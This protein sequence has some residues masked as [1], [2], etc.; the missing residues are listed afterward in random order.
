MRAGRAGASL[1]HWLLLSAALVAIAPAARAQ[2]FNWTGANSTDWAGLGNWT[3]LGIPVSA[4]PEGAAVIVNTIA[5]NATITDLSAFNGGASFSIGSLAIGSAGNTTGDVTFRF[6]TPGSI[7]DHSFDAGSNLTVGANGGSGTLT[8][9]LHGVTR[10]ISLFA[11]TFTFGVGSGSVARINVLGAGTDQSSYGGSV[12]LSTDTAGDIVFGAQGGAAHLVADGA[13]IGISPQS[14]SDRII[15]GSG[16]GSTSTVNALSG[17]KIALGVGNGAAS[18]FG[19]GG[20]ADVTVDGAAADGTPSRLILG[21]GVVFGNGPGG[22]GTLNVLSGGKATS[23]P[24]QPS[25]DPQLG[26]NGG[27]GIATVSGPGSV[28]NILGQTPVGGPVG[29]VGNLH[30]GGPGG[31]GVLTLSD[32]GRVALGQGAIGLNPTPDPVNPSSGLILTD[33]TPGLGTVFVAEQPGSTGTVNFGAPAG[34]APVAPG[35]LDAAAVQFGDGNGR[36]VFNHTAPD[37]T[38]SIPT[39]GPG[40]VQTLAGTTVFDTPG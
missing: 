33:F 28:W 27:T 29:E 7:G 11:S 34:S 1:R 21:G 26:A 4:P 31:T 39:S 30:V 25:P 20:V 10:N 38:Y 23:M 3:L 17:S 8:F 35:T 18:V 13:D 15:F 32:G 9:D 6:L 36:I 2:S 22:R 14:S 19:D 12:A 16:L 37:F 40:T 24:G 5:P